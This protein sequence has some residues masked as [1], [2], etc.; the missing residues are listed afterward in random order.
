MMIE[1]TTLDYL[2]L[3]LRP[4]KVALE[5]PEKAPQKFVRIEKTAQ[6]LKNGISAATLAIQSYAPSLYEAAALS[7]RVIVAMLGIDELS[8][9]GGVRLINEHNFTNPQ[10]KQY[11]YQA[12]FTIYF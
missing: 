8:A 1:K 2:S 11:R 4:I 7:Q 9:I 5:T 3:K 6:A 12:I 10:T